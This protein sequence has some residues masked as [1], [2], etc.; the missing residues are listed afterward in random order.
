MQETLIQRGHW[1]QL[2]VEGQQDVE[3]R[4]DI[5]QAHLDGDPRTMGQMLE[6]AQARDHRPHRFDQ[7]A[8]I[9]GAC[10]TQML[11]FAGCST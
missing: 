8:F 5:G 1:L 3:Q 6:M 10:G 2:L 9:P 7:H 11:T 4:T